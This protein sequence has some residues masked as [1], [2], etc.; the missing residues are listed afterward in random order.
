MKANMLTFGHN[1]PW[2]RSQNQ[3]KPPPFRAHV[4]VCDGDYGECP[5]FSNYCSSRTQTLF[6][7]MFN[8]VYKQTFLTNKNYVIA[9]T[10]TYRNT[11]EHGRGPLLGGGLA[12]P[13]LG[14]QLSDNASLLSQRSCHYL[15][16]GQRRSHGGGLK[17]LKPPLSNQNIDV[18]FLSYSPTL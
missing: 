8:R 12:P 15:N 14:L 3:N 9:H 7:T 6:A 16:Q 2:K 11:H 1:V 13:N 4:T 10:C 18:Y 5:Q 17:G